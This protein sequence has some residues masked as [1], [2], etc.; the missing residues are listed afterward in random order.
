MKIRYPVIGA[1]II[2]V[3]LVG[4]ES[5]IEPQIASILGVLLLVCL[6]LIAYLIIRNIFWAV[7]D[8]VTGE[9]QGGGYRS[10]AKRACEKVTPKRDKNATPPWEK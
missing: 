4:L 1:I 3:I 10:E 9:P 6:G 8:A 5:I 7:K 2:L